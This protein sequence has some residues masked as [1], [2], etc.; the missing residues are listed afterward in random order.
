MASEDCECDSGNSAGGIQDATTA[1]E[2]TTIRILSVGGTSFKSMK[3]LVDAN[4]RAFEESVNGRVNIIV[5]DVGDLGTMA[6]EIRS[7][8]DLE[9]GYFDG[10]VSNPGVVGTAVQKG[11]FMD[12]GSYVHE[13]SDLDWLDILPAFRE[14]ITTYDG[15][16]YMLPLDGDV[17]SMFY[18]IDVLDHFGLSVPRTWDEYVDVAK[19][20]HGKTYNGVELIGSCVGRVKSCVGAYYA[21]TVLASYT[22]TGGTK[23]GYLFD[24]NDMTPLAGEALA[25]AIRQLEE[26]NRFGADDELEDCGGGETTS[27]NIKHFLTEGTCALTY[28]WGDNY[29]LHLS[30]TSKVGGLVGVAP[31]PGSTKVLDRETGKLMPCDAE[32]CKFG[33]KYDDLGWVNQSPYAAFGGWAAGVAGNVS[34]LRQRFAADFFSYASSSIRS[35]LGVIPNATTPLEQ[36]NGQDPYRQSHL[37]V[38]KWEKKGY[39]PE[40]FTTYRDTLL[41]SLSSENL[42]IDIRF[43]ESDKIFGT[44]DS[45]IFDYLQRVKNNEV[46]DANRGAE[47]RAVAESISTEWTSIIETFDQERSL[48]SPPIIEQYQ[49]SLG[50]YRPPQDYNYVG[51]VRYFVFFLASIVVLSSIGFAVWVTLKRKTHT[52]RASQPIFLI[53]ICLGT[54][55]MGG[56]IYPI[57][58]D[59]EI[60]SIQGCDI[61]CMIRPWFMGCGFSCAFSALFSKTLRINKLFGAAKQ[62]TRMTVTVQDVMKPFIVLSSMNIILLSIWT[63]INPMVWE[64]TQTTPTSSYGSCKPQS[65]SG[66]SFVPMVLF[67]LLNVGTLVAAN[68]QA[69]RARGISDEF[70]ESKYVA[71]ALASILQAMIIGGPIA[72][73]TLESP[74]V[75]TL[76][77]S[78]IV[79]IIAMSLLMLMFVP[80]VLM[81][82]KK[83]KEKEK[84]ENQSQDARATISGSSVNTDGIL[85]TRGPEQWSH[86]VTESNIQP[87]SQQHEHKLR[88]LKLKLTEQG[89]DASTLFT[90]VGFELTES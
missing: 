85:I 26:Q 66:A 43:P 36:M 83:A 65:T 20:V 61:A 60:A 57:A 10:F 4:A 64:R 77:V 72:L 22:Q 76:I 79:F 25:E 37:I 56:G 53:L 58:I 21:S 35:Q 89:I 23:S 5:E 71:I 30:S 16:V 63:A 88:E 38:E 51:N 44:L 55:L 33:T 9:E 68:V 32:L 78:A 82:K 81:V 42:A 12:L 75:F 14:V 49:R 18:R 34:P 46:A 39:P 41:S 28:N 62:F 13:S 84:E 24:P 47:R 90:E 52:V 6:N 80:K 87:S 3:D 50:I 11:G 74:K 17:H 40:G 15:K 86:P 67:G 45:K 27:N 8:A 48:S 54:L 19:A 59:D 7:N 31:L 1:G 70:S 2:A 73:M 69:F 29:K